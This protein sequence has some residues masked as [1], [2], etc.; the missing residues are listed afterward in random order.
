MSQTRIKK[1]LPKTEKRK[2][3]NN[4]E[5]FAQPESNS[6]A[7]TNQPLG[8]AGQSPAQMA[9]GI[10]HAAALTK[11]NKEGC[12]CVSASHEH[13]GERCGKPVRFS[14]ET[15]AYQGQGNYG[16]FRRVGICEQ[17]WQKAVVELP[18]LFGDDR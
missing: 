13:N 15:Q 8:T 1:K 10:K 11:A 6:F 4:E 3:D 16:P 14:V 17:C 12:V 9:A 2:K 18:H 5:P 7:T